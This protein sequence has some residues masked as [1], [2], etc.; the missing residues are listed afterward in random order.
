MDGYAPPQVSCGVE[1]VAVP[2]SELPLDLPSLFGVN[3][4]MGPEKSR[5]ISSEAQER[6]AREWIGRAEENAVKAHGGT[7]RFVQAELEDLSP[8]EDGSLAFAT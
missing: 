4:K 1:K 7:P 8:L 2:L 6:L 5:D 3:W